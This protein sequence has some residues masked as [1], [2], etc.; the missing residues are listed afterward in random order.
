MEVREAKGFWPVLTEQ[1]SLTQGCL[2]Q[3]SDVFEQ[4]TLTLRTLISFF[5]SSLGLCLDNCRIIATK[6]FIGPASFE[7]LSPSVPLAFLDMW[8]YVFLLL[9]FGKKETRVWLLEFA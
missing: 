4:Y 3:H 1:P 9:D 7:H 5:L 8:W 2:D 6:T